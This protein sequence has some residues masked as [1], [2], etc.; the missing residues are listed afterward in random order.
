MYKCFEEIDTR[1]NN[2]INFNPCIGCKFRGKCESEAYSLPGEYCREKVA[3][4]LSDKKSRSV[5]RQIKTG[6]M[7]L[8]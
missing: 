2:N 5:A 7:D 1:V 3:K 4:K 6:E 8:N